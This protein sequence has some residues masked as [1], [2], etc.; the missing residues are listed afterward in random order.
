MTLASTVGVVFLGLLLLAGGLWVAS[1]GWVI[2]Q[3][4]RNEDPN[5]LAWS[6]GAV[7]LGYLGPVLYIVTQNSARDAVYGPRTE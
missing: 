5:A 7:F 3:T 4:R 6:V 2:R 1:A